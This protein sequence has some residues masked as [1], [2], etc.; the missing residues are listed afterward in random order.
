MVKKFNHVSLIFADKLFE[1]VWPFSGIGA[2]RV[3]L[4]VYHALSG[5]YYFVVTKNTC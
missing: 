4:N 2:Q 5:Q 1:C 3:D